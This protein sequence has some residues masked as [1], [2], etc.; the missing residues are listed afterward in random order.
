MGKRA[1]RRA[2]R[3]AAYAAMI[4]AGV[5][6]AVAA[7]SAN[8]PRMQTVNQRVQR[9]SNYSDMI[10][11]GVDSNLA[12]AVANNPNI[13]AVPQLTEKAIA[14]QEEYNAE[15]EAVNMAQEARAQQ[16]KLLAAIAKGPPKA[17]RALR[18]SGYRPRFRT[19]ASSADRSRRTSQGSAQFANP[20]SMGGSYGSTGIN[21]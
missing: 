8:A 1:R 12:N 21:V 10:N 7:Q 2:R 6:P 16:N 15:T 11:V 13:K 20:L 14:Q 18:G 9:S 5:N 3:A 19:R 4:N 17:S